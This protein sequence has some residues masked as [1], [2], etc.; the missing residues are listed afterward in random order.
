VKTRPT[1]PPSPLLFHRGL[2]H[3]PEELHRDGQDLD[4]D[5][6]LN[7]AANQLEYDG[8]QAG[9]HQESAAW[10]DSSQGLNAARQQ[11]CGDD[12][13]GPCQDEVGDPEAVLNSLDFLLHSLLGFLQFRIQTGLSRPGK[14]GL[15][16]FPDD[17]SDGAQQ[18]RNPSCSSQNDRRD[19]NGFDTPE[20]RSRTA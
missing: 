1:T 3:L 5:N 13:V 6:R 8:R 16:L 11:Q 10:T 4:L 2:D 19:A 9:S 14:G 15:K 20:P 17:Q 18:R 7:R 12:H